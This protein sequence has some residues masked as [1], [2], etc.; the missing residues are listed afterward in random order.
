MNEV[1]LEEIM[2]QPQAIEVSLPNLREQ[3]VNF[4][5][6]LDTFKRIIFCG[7][8]DSYFAGEALST[9][10]RKY[11]GKEVVVLPSQE[12]LSYWNFASTDL[13]VPISISGE[14]KRTVL[15]ARRARQDKACIIAITANAGS[16]L[17][18]A[19]DHTLTIPFKERTRKTPHTTD[20]LT[21]LLSIAVLVELFHQKPLTVLDTLSGL[22]QQSLNDNHSHCVEIGKQLA[23]RERYYFFGDGPNWGT[24]QYG[25]AKFWEAR[26]IDALAFEIDEVGHGLHMVLQKGDPVFVPAPKGKTH[27]RISAALNGYQLLNAQCFVI[28]DVPQSFT[29]FSTLIIP[30]IE[31]EFSPFLTCLPLQLLCWAIANSKNYD[32][33]MGGRFASGE[34]YDDVLSFL[35][36]E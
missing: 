8:G 4:P 30:E 26:G 21:T 11:T 7:S 29:G 6:A 15:A 13:F 1:M 31:E 9:A 5:L 18:A 3:A 27:K 33:F 19:S 32:V 36:G 20:Y 12:A 2:D 28:T 17:A 35:R 14:T 24:C 10:A 23:D 16:S 34:T 22:V 25:A